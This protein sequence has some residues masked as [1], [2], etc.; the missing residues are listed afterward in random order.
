[1]LRLYFLLLTSTAILTTSYIRGTYIP[2]TEEE[3]G[4]YHNLLRN[5]WSGWELF[6]PAARS[7]LLFSPSPFDPPRSRP[8]AF[9]RLPSA[10]PDPPTGPWQSNHDGVLWPGGGWPS[11][12]SDKSDTSFNIYDNTNKM[13]SKNL[14]L[15]VTTWILTVNI[16]EINFKMT[17]ARALKQRQFTRFFPGSDMRVA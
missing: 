3:K 11:I 8:H 6:V 12:T 5:T 17:K 15:P 14:K 9:D 13:V 16:L 4:G 1:M 2:F 7:H 10:L